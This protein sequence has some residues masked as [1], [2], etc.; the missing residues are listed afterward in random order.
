MLRKN[1]KAGGSADNIAY[2]K[3]AKYLTTHEKIVCKLLS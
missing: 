1:V 2:N 3:V